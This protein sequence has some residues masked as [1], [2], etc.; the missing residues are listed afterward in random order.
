M[1]GVEG[2]VGICEGEMIGVGAAVGIQAADVGETVGDST[3]AW[4]AG[5]DAT[6]G[7]STTVARTK[8]EETGAAGTEQVGGTGGED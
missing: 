1:I 6:E 5:G 2:A 3:T 4:V 7:D 8:G